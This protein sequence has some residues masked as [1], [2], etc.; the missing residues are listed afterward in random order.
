MFERELERIAQ[1]LLA[2]SD[3]R[4]AIEWPDLDIED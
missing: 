4:V 2:N 1:R 3:A